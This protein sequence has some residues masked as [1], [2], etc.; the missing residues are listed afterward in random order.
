MDT[1]RL[2]IEG[3]TCDHCVRAVR[4]A[5]EGV[6]GARVDSVAIGSAT[7]RYDPSRTSPDAL[8]DA[9]NDEGYAASRAE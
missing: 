5:L 9:V 1:L 7:V 2:D 6:E 8:V 3:M 4:T